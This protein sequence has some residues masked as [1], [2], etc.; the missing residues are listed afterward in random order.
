MRYML[1]ECKEEYVLLDKELEQLENFVNLSK[2]Q[3]EERGEVVFENHVPP[4]AYK[5]APLL[6]S[7]F[8]ENAFKHSLSSLSENIHIHIQLKLQGENTLKFSC[9]NT[10]STQTNTDDLTHGIGLENVKKRL[11]LLYPQAHQLEIHCDEGLYQ[12]SLTLQLDPT[13]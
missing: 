7:V 2:L 12:V 9:T 1:Y 3:L 4:G 11:N 5:I 13:T 6:L 8:V 10:Y